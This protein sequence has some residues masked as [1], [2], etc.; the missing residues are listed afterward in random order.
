VNVVKQYHAADLKEFYCLG[1]VISGTL[2][3]GM[4][5]KILGEGYNK[6]EEEDQDFKDVKR[7]W[8]F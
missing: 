3:R 5:V 1:R 2:K 7:L 4:K 6:E 8:I